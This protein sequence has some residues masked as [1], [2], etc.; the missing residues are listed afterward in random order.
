MGF[1]VTQL[2]VTYSYLLCSISKLFVFVM[3]VIV[4]GM[5]CTEFDASHQLHAACVRRLHGCLIPGRTIT[6][7]NT[8]NHNL[9]IGT[10]LG[11]YTGTRYQHRTE[12]RL[13]KYRGILVSIFNGML[14]GILQNTNPCQT[15]NTTK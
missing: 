5:I 6:N 12:Y 7:L 10:D 13:A 11:L 2:A 8:A 15:F 3:R 9:R 14:I 1:T 4:D